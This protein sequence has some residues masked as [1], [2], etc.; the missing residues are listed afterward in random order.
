MAV[1]EAHVEEGEILQGERLEG[2]KVL[3]GESNGKR[4]KL[5]GT[6]GLTSNARNPVQLAGSM[7]SPATI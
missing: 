3:T 1:K 2:T 6:E 5:M 7:Q 4:E